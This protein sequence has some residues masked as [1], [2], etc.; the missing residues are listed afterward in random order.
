VSRVTVNG[1]GLNVEIAGE[2]P[3]VLLLHGFTGSVAT[4]AP[5]R[6]AW[7]GFAT[8][9]VD[10]LGHGDSDCPAEVERYGIG[11][12]LADLS[13][14]LDVLGARR[15]AVLGYS[16]G[17]R[18]ALHLALDLAARAPERVTALVLESTS[19]GIESA[20]EREARAASDAMLAAA[21]ERDGTA[22]FVARW[23]AL[24]LFATQAH[25]P[26]ATRAALRHQRLANHPRGLA[27]SLRA[28]SV[29]RHAPLHT[30][31]PGL[32]LPTLLLA[33]ELDDAYRR[34][35]EWMGA[36]LPRARVVVVPEAGHAVHLEQPAAFARAVRD[37]LEATI[38]ADAA[39]TPPKEGMPCP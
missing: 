23:E 24:P 4:W 1:V 26:A 33:G 36:T 37:F 9:A 30:R 35:A 22:A 17:G 11:P 6:D 21:I 34:H 5:H 16:M 14:L 38:G 7:R 18:I 20:P 2:G 39:T 15:T 25:L 27:H 8:I 32:R 29:G 3:H 28:L 12:T 31:L 10:L 13:S 19:P